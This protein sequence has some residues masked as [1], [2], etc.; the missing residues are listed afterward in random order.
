MVSLLVKE[1]L[2]LISSMLPIKKHFLDRLSD[3]FVKGAFLPK[4][5]LVFSDLFYTCNR[6]SVTEIMDMYRENNEILSVKKNTKPGFL[7]SKLVKSLR[8]AFISYPR[9]IYILYVPKVITNSTNVVL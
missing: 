2:W 6:V 1:E 9:I 3:M 4:N 8:K 7:A 5:K